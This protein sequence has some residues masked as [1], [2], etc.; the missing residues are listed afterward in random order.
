MES[1]DEQ[2]FELFFAER[3]KTKGFTLKKLSEMSGVALKHLENLRAGR[4][5]DLPPAPYLHGYLRSIGKFLDFDGEAH[6]FQLRGDALQE[7]GPVL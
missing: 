7:S 6:R 2:P 5:E 1:L 3:L 4:Y